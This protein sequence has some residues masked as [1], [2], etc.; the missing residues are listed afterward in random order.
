MLERKLG[1]D[2]PGLG[3]LQTANTP[4]Q[5]PPAKSEEA[6]SNSIIAVE[7]NINEKIAPQEIASQ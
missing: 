5:A 6:S 2:L 7:F 4:F 1:I 3:D